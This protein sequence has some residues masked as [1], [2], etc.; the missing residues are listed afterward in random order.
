[1]KP[2]DISGIKMNE[3]AT[4]TVNRNIW[5]LYRGIN[6]VKRSSQPEMNLMKNENCEERCLLGCYAVW[7]L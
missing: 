4:K 5:D 7:L 1:V 3:L 2:T 6:G